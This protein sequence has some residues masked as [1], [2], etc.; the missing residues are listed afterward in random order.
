MLG[1]I[2]PGRSLG[3]GEPFLV[4]DQPCDVNADDLPLT[5]ELMVFSLPVGGAELDGLGEP[6]DVLPVELDVTGR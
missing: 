6:P 2:H 3:F 1:R 5:V 4:D